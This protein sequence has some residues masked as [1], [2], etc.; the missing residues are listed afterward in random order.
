MFEG[1]TVLVTGGTG[2]FG[3]AFVKRLLKEPIKKLI[4]FS[5][6]ELKQHEMRTQEGYT[7]ERL[8]FFLGDIRDVDRLRRAF[9]GVDIVVHAAALKQVPATEYNPFEAVKTNILGSQNVIDAALDRNVERAILISSDKAVLPVNLYGSTKLAAEKLFVAANHYRSNAS[10]TRFGVIRYGNVVGS[11][12]SFV[13]AVRKQVG[14]GK[15]TLT[16]EDM[17]RFW[18]PID[19]VMEVVLEAL[20]LM[21][22]GEIFIPKMKSLGVKD[23]ATLLAPTCTIETIGIR[24]G[25]KMH[26][27]LITEHEEARTRDIGS[28][29]VIQPEFTFGS[30]EASWLDAKPLAPAKLGYSSDNLAFRMQEDEARKLLAL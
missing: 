23:V 26:E 24:P 21:Q 6:D 16:H 27:V 10:S 18:I 22:G 12:G 4:I 1:K 30:T 2:T 9:D 28:M 3:H 19:S 13:E 25:E 5:R 7:D 8:R 29:F 11:R 14:G 20:T 15:I 17:T